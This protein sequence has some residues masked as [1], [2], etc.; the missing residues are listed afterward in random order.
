MPDGT[1]LSSAEVPI[2]QVQQHIC[3]AYYAGMI[4]EQL[5][6]GHKNLHDIARS[7]P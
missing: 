2:S 6:V 7:A 1:V 3:H 4:F 5:D